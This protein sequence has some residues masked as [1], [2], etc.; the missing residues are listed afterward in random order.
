MYNYEEQKEA[1]FT[2]EGQKLFL[3]IRDRIKELLSYGSGAV[4][5]EEAILKQGSDGWMK[6]A[7]VDRLVE[8]GELK[9]VSPPHTIQ[10]YR[11]FVAAK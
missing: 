2:D 11:I 10:Q 1:L 3:R 6:L 9:E 5:M 4:R 8:L 7:C